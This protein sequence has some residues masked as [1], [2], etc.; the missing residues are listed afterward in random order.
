MTAEICVHLLAGLTAVVCL[1]TDDP[2]QARDMQCAWRHRRCLSPTCPVTCA[3]WLVPPSLP[4]L[5]PPS[6][7]WLFT[8]LGDGQ[9][10]RTWWPT[11]CDW[12]AQLLRHAQA[13]SLP[14]LPHPPEKTAPSS[15]A[16]DGTA[17]LHTQT[18][19]VRDDHHPFSSHVC[20]RVAPTGVCM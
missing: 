7:L 14:V 8:H 19:G 20:E 18:I 10:K 11:V 15:T 2:L 13:Q 16:G 6:C 1:T 4:P 3:E 9:F 5:P 12:L 17:G